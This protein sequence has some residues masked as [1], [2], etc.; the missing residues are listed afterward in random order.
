MAD[1]R[2]SRIQDSEPKAQAI[3]TDNT[4]EKTKNH[5]RSGIGGGKKGEKEAGME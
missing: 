4:L 1:N 2:R 5:Y 3:E